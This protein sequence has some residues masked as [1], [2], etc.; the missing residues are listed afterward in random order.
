MNKPLIKNDVVK[1]FN[2]NRLVPIHF[3]SLILTVKLAV[4]ILVTLLK[5]YSVLTIAKIMINTM[6]Q[7]QSGEHLLYLLLMLQQK[8]RIQLNLNVIMTKTFGIFQKRK[9]MLVK[10][11]KR[12]S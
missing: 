5:M 10:N 9:F 4:V 7:E 6:D 3:S 12:K 2:K 11:R 8:K 1:I